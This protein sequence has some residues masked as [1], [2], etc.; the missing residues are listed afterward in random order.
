MAS[1]LTRP[2]FIELIDMNYFKREGIREHEV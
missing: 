1:L 2:A